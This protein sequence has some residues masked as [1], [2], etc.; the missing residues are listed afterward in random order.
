MGLYKEEASVFDNIE[1]NQY[2]IWDD[3]CDTGVLVTG[4]DD[5]I[6]LELFRNI[7]NLKELIQNRVTYGDK[8]FGGVTVDIL[9]PWEKEGNQYSC[10]K[11][12]ISYHYDAATHSRA[13][14]FVN[15]YSD[16]VIASDPWA[17]AKHYDIFN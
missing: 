15:V 5:P 2:Q 6:V 11:Y 1:H 10:T 8:K 17:S 13:K 16:R 14:T 4:K 12:S 3:A 9:I 7:K